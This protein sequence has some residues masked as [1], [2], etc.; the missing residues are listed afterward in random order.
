ML[1]IQFN[2]QK[3]TCMLR[4]GGSGGGESVDRGLAGRRMVLSM[5]LLLIQ[6]MMASRAS[7]RWPTAVR[8]SRCPSLCIT[9]CSS[10]PPDTT[11]VTVDDVNRSKSNIAAVDSLRLLF[12]TQADL[13]TRCCV[14]NGNK[15]RKRH[16]ASN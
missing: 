15:Q 9:C 5:L 8:R 10:R 14:R 13:R 2:S 1:K 6:L 11:S 12:A 16:N 4:T 3:V 7:H